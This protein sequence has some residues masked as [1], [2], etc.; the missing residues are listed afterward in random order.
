MRKKKPAK[1]KSANRKNVKRST[2]SIQHRKSGHSQGPAGGPSAQI[3]QGVGI[4]I[5]EA[6]ISTNEVSEN[7]VGGKK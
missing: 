3:H 1:K 7:E 2:K 4:A 5:A 6:E